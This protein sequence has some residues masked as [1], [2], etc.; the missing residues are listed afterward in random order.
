MIEARGEL[1]RSDIESKQS[2]T[3]AEILTEM[4]ECQLRA[5]LR[6]IVVVPDGIS[7]RFTC[8]GKTDASVPLVILL[9]AYAEEG[10][11]AIYDLITSTIKRM[12]FDI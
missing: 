7:V 8:E 1:L 9:A 10:P 11:D 5:D 12:G 2:H 4:M 3:T 6:S